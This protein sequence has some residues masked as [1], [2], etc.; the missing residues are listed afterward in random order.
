MRK[1]LREKPLSPFLFPRCVLGKLWGKYFPDV[2]V[3]L[4]CL[5]A[6]VAS[7]EKRNQTYRIVFR[8]DGKRHGFSLGTGDRHEAETLAGGVEKTLM[9]LEHNLRKLHACVDIVTLA[10]NDR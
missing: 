8:Y 10:K 1:G 2:E 5:E 3:A 7:L 9:R 6:T 4:P